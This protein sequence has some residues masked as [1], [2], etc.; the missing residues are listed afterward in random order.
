MF[1]V[2]SDGFWWVLE[3]TGWFWWGLVGSG[4]VLVVS[5]GFLLVLVGS[6]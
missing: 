3:V 1:Q 6:L 2:G 5:S 4:G